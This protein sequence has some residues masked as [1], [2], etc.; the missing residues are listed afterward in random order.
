MCTN[1]NFKS[2]SWVGR[3]CVCNCCIAIMSH[4]LALYQIAICIKEMFVKRTERRKRKMFYVKRRICLVKNERIKII[5]LFNFYTNTALK[6]VM[7]IRKSDKHENDP[8]TQYSINK[9]NLNYNVPK[10]EKR[11]LRKGKKREKKTVNDI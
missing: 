7:L 6:I 5:G 10:I 1:Y 2:T 11:K 9:F 4:F 3:G 8:Q